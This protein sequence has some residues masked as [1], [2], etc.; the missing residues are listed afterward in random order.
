MNGLENLL[1]NPWAQFWP[2]RRISAIGAGVG[3][4]LAVLL[5][6]VLPAAWDAR[7]TVGPAGRGAGPDLSAFMP[8]SESPTIQYLLQRVG[9]VT[10]ADFAVYEMLMTSPRVATALVKDETI[11]T[12]LN[13]VCGNCGRDTAKLSHWLSGHVRIQPVG[14][15]QMRRITV[16]L[17]DKTLATDLL[18]A[19]HRLSD[20][21]IR[22]DV[23]VR[24][25]QRIAYLREQLGG[26]ANLDQRDA[27]IGLLKEQERTRMMVG[28]DSDFAA[29]IIDP[30]S[31][32][33]RP[34]CP[35][36]YM[37]LPLLALLGA[38]GGFGYGLYSARAQ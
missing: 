2:H 25:D 8:A 14:A 1:T 29:E 6:L 26:V 5:W 27:M 21:T 4:V 16:R 18:R 38:A 17:H 24:T 23:R 3:V 34:A 13:D 15:T 20:E 11:K 30:P 9:A 32:P 28:I 7:M 35:N 22:A 37:L 19:L 33:D 31:L 12:R 36:L 10:A